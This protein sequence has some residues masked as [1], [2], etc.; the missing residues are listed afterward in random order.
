M[1][2]NWPLNV[3]N[4]LSAQFSFSFSHSFKGKYGQI[5]S[6]QPPPPFFLRLKPPQCSLR[7]L[8][9][10]LRNPGSTTGF[11]YTYICLKHN[12]YHGHVL[13]ISYCTFLRVTTEFCQRKKNVVIWGNLDQ[14]HV[15]SKITKSGQMQVVHKIKIKVKSILL[16]HYNLPFHKNVFL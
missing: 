6:C 12:A 1:E 4:G 5:I 2:E 13:E 3:R 14:S 15:R 7:C 11:S 9:L 8:R 16:L 10:Y